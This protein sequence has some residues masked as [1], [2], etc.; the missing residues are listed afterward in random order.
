MAHD[1]AKA[2]S[3]GIVVPPPLIFLGALALGIGADRLF[4]APGVV[5]GGI[6]NTTLACLP[7]AGGSVLIGISLG[8]FRRAKTRP[9]PWQP[10]TMLVISGIYRYTRNPMYLG[11]LLVYL[12]LAFAFKSLIPLLLVPLVIAIIHGY[13]IRREEAY[14]LE[15]FGEEYSRY[16][17]EVR[18]WI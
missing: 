10:S 17:S 12:G 3:A 6:L 16:Q 5:L 11:M 8:L 1:R 9:E 7:L 4:G 18:P 14:L 13:V 15:K 2:A